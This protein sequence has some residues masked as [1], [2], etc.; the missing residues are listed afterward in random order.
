MSYV[1]NY[2]AGQ[3][4]VDLLNTVGFDEPP[5]VQYTHELPLLSFGDVQHNLN[6]S[7]VFNY[8]RYRD[9]KANNKNPFFIA[10]GFKLNLHKRLIINQYDLLTAFQGEDGRNI[11]IVSFGNKFTFDDESQRIIRRT[12]HVQKPIGG[13]TLPED[14]LTT[15]TY[16]VEHSDFS[17][18]DYNESGRITNSYDKYGNVVLSYTYNTSGQLTSVTFRGSKTVTLAYASNR[19]NSITY[20]GKTTT[21]N[22]KSDGSL[23]YVQHYTGVKY[24]FT[25]SKP[26]YSAYDVNF[27]CKASATENSAT[28]SYSKNLT[29]VY[30]SNNYAYKVNVIDKIGS[31]AVNTVTYRFPK[32][33]ALLETK[34]PFKYVDII[35][36]NG[37]ETR[38]QI[39]DHKAMCSYEVQN[40]EPQFESD[41]NKFIGDVTLYNSESGLKNAQSTGVQTRNSGLVIID[42][43]KN[44]YHC[45]QMDIGLSVVKK[46][47]Y[48]V[49]GWV[50]SSD[51]NHKSKTFFINNS[52]ATVN[53]LDIYL[54]PNGIWQYF[55]LTT[56]IEANYIYAKVEQDSAEFKDVRFTCCGSLDTE[57]STWHMRSTEYN[58]LYG[59]VEIPF[60][61]ARFYYTSGGTNTEI[62]GTDESDEKQVNFADALRYKLRKKRDGV[63]NEVYYNNC[64]DIVT[65]TTD[66]K[67][68]HGGSYISISNFDLGVK[69]YFPGRTSLTRITVD[70]NNQ[71]SNIVK[72]CKVTQKTGETTEETTEVSTEKLNKY[73]DTVESTSEGITNYYE[74]ASTN[75]GL[76]S[77][78]TSAPVG[79]SKDNTTNSKVIVKRYNY[80]TGL[81]KL[82]SVIDEFGKTTTY[83]TDD[84]Y[85]VVTGVTLPDGAVVTDAYDDDK[86]TLT[87]RKFASATNSRNTK[88]SYSKGMLNSLIHRDANDLIEFA[89]GYDKGKLI[90][91]EKDTSVIE[92]HE[93]PSDTQAKNYYPSKSSALHSQ[94]C[95]YDKYGRLTKID[96]V[97]ENTYDADPYW[98]YLDDSSKSHFTMDEYND[99]VLHRVI[100]GVSCKDALIAKATDSLTGEDTEYGY[101]NKQLTRTITCD[102]SGSAVRQE[103]FVYDDIGRLTKDSFDYDIAAGKHIASEIVYDTST[104]DPVADNRVKN[105]SYK[106]NGTEKA[107]TVNGYDDYK[108]VTSKNY[109]VGD[110]AFTKTFTYNKT[111]ISRVVDGVGGTT[112]YEYDSVGRISKEKDGSGNILRSYTYDSY[113]QLTRENNKGL[114]K[115]FVFEYNNIGNV[116]AV[117]TYAYTTGTL[118]SVISQQSFGY[119]ATYPDRLTACG[120]TT[121]SYNSMGCPTTV[122][123]YTATW[124]RGKLSKLTKGS[125]ITGTHT[126]NYT[127]NAFGQRIGINYSY[128]AGTSSS[129]AVVMGMLTSYSQTFKYDQSGRL[130]YESKTSQYHGEG[131]GTE[132]KVYLYDESGIIG[133]V[134]T[135]ESGTTTTYYFQRNL[136]GD[137][138]GIYTNSGTKVGGYAYDAWGNCTITL[139]S[140][141]SAI[142][143][144]IR[145]R[146]YYYDED[147]KL[148]FLNARYYCPEWRRFISPD[149]TAYLDPESVNGLNLYAYCNNDPVNYADPS[150]CK[151]ASI[152]KT[153]LGVGIGIG[154]AAVAITATILTGGSFAAIG[155]GFAL[156]ATASFVGQGVGNVLSGEN[157][158]DGISI[159]SIIM[160]GL[161]GAAFA[162]GFGGFW[163]A[164]AIG[165]A[166]NAGTSALENKSWAN[167]AGSAI[168]G[169]IAAGIGYGVGRFVTSYVY[170]TSGMSFNDFY[171]LGRIDTNPVKAAYHAFRASWNTFLP[172]ISTS[173]SRGLIKFLG[174]K[175]IGWF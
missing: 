17:K 90:K 44:H 154:L 139:N 87:S 66:L 41:T 146:G 150:G 158:F 14:D 67:V 102:S 22:Y 174:N 58:L 162:T 77:K 20:N 46:G 119:D 9:E 11:D 68:L 172:N 39:F 51:V 4:N 60:E 25:L 54:E 19:L 173:A 38:M 43:P 32:T 120:G 161:A 47:C 82:N 117:K 170:R 64:K 152:W 124:T 140:D 122:N 53:G 160:G 75:C 141:G 49:S 88:F 164:V 16:A 34:P 101:Y 79:V 80:D 13:N 106:V 165:A 76:I 89:F 57:D 114:D 110:K 10:P 143:N 71:S 103:F 23:N 137:V 70:D 111:R 36:N 130:I 135:S 145:Y 153:I 151:S 69:N 72:V 65:G 81:T 97:V 37:V 94:I 155:V 96:G 8:E 50:R 1:K 113:G 74:Y 138:V 30:E 129:S 55:S 175:G 131:S 35:D 148:Y 33:I 112:Q 45:W 31:N 95:T 92:E 21:F 147:T 42:H 108:R 6:L 99:E 24:T 86:C 115:S 12:A 52:G 136:L 123:G 128:M 15:Y 171:G 107:K 59:N 85:G 149:D 169:G 125:R 7:L 61:D 121:I 29:L 18:E 62:K 56:Y 126:Y 93:H 27:E 40:G 91:V 142:R 26:S 167:I 134:Y 104:T 2:D 73:L 78:Q 5:Y 63:S 109:T 156:G 163:G 166:S 157:F 159:G 98:F 118:G 28:V 144:P 132:K 84:I 100:Q 116:V 48:T 3:I 83:T 133:M 105:Y 168:V 127:Y